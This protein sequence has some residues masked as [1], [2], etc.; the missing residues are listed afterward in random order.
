MNSK[1]KADRLEKRL[2]EFSSNILKLA[3][4]LPKNPEN[5]IYG[6]QIIRSSS[7]TGANFA[8]ATCAHTKKDFTHDINK[9]RKEARETIYWLKLLHMA[10][11][12]FNK[13]IEILAQEAKEI[14]K[15]FSSAVKTAKQNP[16][17]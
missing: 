6:N 13:K 14:F 17:C 3:K 11:P 8:E 15:I 2:L 4:S 7:S 10:N 12:N 5:R 1:T 9:S 16:K